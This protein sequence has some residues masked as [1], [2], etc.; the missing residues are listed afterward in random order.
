[1]RKPVVPVLADPQLIDK[2]LLEVQ[3]ALTT[4]LVWLDGAYGKVQRLTE[5]REKRRI[6]FPA[7]YT[8]SKKGIGYE[9]AM[10]SNHLGNFSFFS[11]KDGEK[12][13]TASRT[14]TKINAEFGLIFWFRYDKIYPADHKE[15]TIE[16][17]K[18]EVLDFF[19]TTAFI[20]SSIVIEQFFELPENIYKGFTDREVENDYLMRPYGG[21]RLNGKIR[22][23][24][25]ANC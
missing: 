11:I 6:N 1:M 12:L 14:N 5:V 3:T 18:K 10:P 23:N 4:K 19:K 22:I 17:V 15:R 21:L 8:G 16:N 25:I 24:Q 9:S 2:A 7:I 20:S 13:D